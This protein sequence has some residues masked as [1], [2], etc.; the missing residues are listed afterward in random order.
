ME[1]I[2]A[3]TL[4]STDANYLALYDRWLDVNHTLNLAGTGFQSLQKLKSYLQ[5]VGHSGD[6]LS[7][8]VA[9]RGEVIDTDVEL[10]KSGDTIILANCEK[11]LFFPFYSSVGSTQVSSATFVKTGGGTIA[12]TYEHGTDEIFLDGVK[13]VYGETFLL[14]NLPVILSRG[15]IIFLFE[16]AV[17][18]AFPYIGTQSEVLQKAGPSFAAGSITK[19][20]MQLGLD[21]VHRRQYISDMSGVVEV[22]NISASGDLANDNV[23]YSW[24]VLHTRDDRKMVMQ[25][26]LVCSSSEVGIQAVGVSEEAVQTTF[27]V[28]GLSFNSDNASIFLG[29]NKQFRIGYLPA[30]RVFQDRL[31]FEHLDLSTHE[32]VTKAEFMGI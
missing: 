21:G 15:S 31:V 19:S 28:D 20:F 18:T 4:A 9:I 16:D 22:S 8:R 7:V 25:P 10:H 17:P 26:T 13:K 27:G 23:S 2:R 12:L 29:S 32:Y 30:D 3:S 5:N 11:S 14:D 24:N 6:I 1:S